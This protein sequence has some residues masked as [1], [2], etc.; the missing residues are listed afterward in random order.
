M[1]ICDYKNAIL[2]GGGTGIG[3]YGDKTRQSNSNEEVVVWLQN[4]IVQV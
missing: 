1:I 2:S 4:Q 3:H